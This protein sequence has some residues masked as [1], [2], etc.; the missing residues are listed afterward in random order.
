MIV[1]DDC[2]TY[3]V[4]HEDGQVVDHSLVPDQPEAV[5][6]GQGDEQVLVDLDASTSQ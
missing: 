2:M 4:L 6:E 3:P 5:V 1:T